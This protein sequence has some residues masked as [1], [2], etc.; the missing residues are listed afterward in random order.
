[1]WSNISVAQ[2]RGGHLEMQNGRCCEVKCNRQIQNNQ[3]AGLSQT[4]THL[5]DF[6]WRTRLAWLRILAAIL[7]FK[8]VDMNEHVIV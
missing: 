5:F 4:I 1:M 7:T 2:D 3:T 6:A 8:M